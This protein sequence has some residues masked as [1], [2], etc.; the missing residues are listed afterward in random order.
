MAY[1]LPV[2]ATR[3]AASGLEAAVAGVHYVEADGPESFADSLAE[4]VK[5]GGAEIGRRGRALA[6]KEYSIEALAALLGG[7]G[8]GSR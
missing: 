1:G 8:H 2:V 5:G 6:E 4:T 7:N 3:L